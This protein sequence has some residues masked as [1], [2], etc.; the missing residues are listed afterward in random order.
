[1]F[2]ENVEPYHMLS[3]TFFGKLSKP[4]TKGTFLSPV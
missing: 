1:M 2:G 4:D 3:Y